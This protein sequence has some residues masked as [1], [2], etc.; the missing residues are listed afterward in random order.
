MILIYIL[1]H[2]CGLPSILSVAKDQSKIE[3]GG[4]VK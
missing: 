1:V 4:T 3:M 2:T